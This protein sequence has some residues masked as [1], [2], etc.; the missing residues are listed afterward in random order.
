MS[1]DYCA[2]ERNESYD[3]CSRWRPELVATIAIW[4][5]SSIGAAL[6]FSP[7]TSMATAILVRRG[8]RLMG[9]A[10]S[11][12]LRLAYRKRLI[13]AIIPRIEA[14]GVICCDFKRF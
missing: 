14:L 5:A 12:P 3:N 2:R 8:R 13:A 10:G 11:C 7:K 9:Y 6:G 1:L 4:S